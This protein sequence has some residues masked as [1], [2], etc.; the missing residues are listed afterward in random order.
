MAPHRTNLRSWCFA[1][2]LLWSHLLIPTN[3]KSF[4]KP[5]L[6]W[7]E[8]VCICSISESAPS[9]LSSP[10]P[11]SHPTE[12][13]SSQ[14]MWSASWWRCILTG[15]S[16]IVAGAS[17]SNSKVAA[18]FF[19][20]RMHSHWPFSQWVI[21]MINDL[22]FHQQQKLYLLYSLDIDLFCF[23]QMGTPDKAL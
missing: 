13:S 10:T 18:M 14:V 11:F 19:K 3:I 12:S 16:D 22:H 6:P 9:C 15:A 1:D 23:A 7:S 2:F 20:Q 21:N 17:D 5:K 8:M 4:V